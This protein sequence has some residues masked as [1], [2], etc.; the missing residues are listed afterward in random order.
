MR[1]EIAFTLLSDKA[2]LP[3]RA[4]AKSAGYDLYSPRDYQVT[5]SG[6]VIPIGV[7]VQLPTSTC[8][9]I[10]G[11]SGLAVKHGVIA[12]NGLIDEDYDGEL[13]VML[14]TLSGPY[15]VSRGDRISQLIVVDCITGDGVDTVRNGGFGSTGV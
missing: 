1:Q 14:W 11:R 7:S 6:V 5:K 4:T 15:K 8:G 10:M 2:T 13:S 3:T 9:V 12:I